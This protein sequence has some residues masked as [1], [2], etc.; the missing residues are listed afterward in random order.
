MEKQDLT[1]YSENEL[2]LIVMNDEY[3]YKMRRQ[4]LR[5]PKL[6]DEYFIFDDDQLEVLLQDLRDDLEET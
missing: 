6:L 2:S 4:I 3:L 1:Q 5:S